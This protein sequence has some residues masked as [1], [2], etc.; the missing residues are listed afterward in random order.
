MALIVKKFGGTSVGS[1][2]RIEAVADLVIRAKQQGHQ[3]VVVVSAMSGETNRLLSLAKQI[4]DRPSAREL[5]V[6]LTTGEQV[7]IAL[8]AMAIIKRGHSAVSLLADQIGIKTDNI[9]GKA[10]IQSIDV[11]RL[12]Q[13]LEHNR[14]AIVA[15]FQGRDIEGNITTLGRGGTD[16]SAVEIAAAICADECQI[17]TDV[18][19]VYTTD[20]RVEP[21]ARRMAQ[22]TFEE[23][24]ELSSLGAKVLQ[25]RSVEAAGKYNIPLRVLS[26]FKPDSG[27]LISYEEPKVA[28][29]T[30]SGIAYQKDEALLLVRQLPENPHSLAKI[31]CL[32]ADYDIEV[33]MISQ[34]NHQGGK[35]DYALT[36]HSNEYAQ[37]LDVL[38]TNLSELGASNVEGDQQVAKISAVGV[39]MKSHSGVAG[40]FF[41]ALAKENIH[42]LLVSTSEIKISVLVEERYLELAV[43]TLHSAFSLESS[44]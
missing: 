44:E 11:N 28:T 41:D 21:R 5:D 25:I 4:D 26:T 38:T 24:L 22:I 14:I 42:T 20:P 12:Q 37:A 16:T 23:M 7:S 30:V 39:G 17:Y 13:E 3:V 32:L 10:R 43:R 29:K 15:G 19:G 1:I 35:I 8:L 40:T 6:L 33:D 31:L 34:I 18:D 36:V 9:F 2:E 27:T